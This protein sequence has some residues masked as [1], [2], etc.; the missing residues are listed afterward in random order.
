VP[1]A[2]D[3]VQYRDD[4]VAQLY[5]SG[6][7]RLHAVRIIGASLPEEYCDGTG[8]C[9]TRPDTQSAGPGYNSLTGLGTLGPNF[10]GDLAKSS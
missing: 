10:V 5:G 8:N 3:Q 9:A 7:G 2:Q 6:S 1:V 4:F